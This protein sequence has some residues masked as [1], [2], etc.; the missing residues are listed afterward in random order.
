[1][2]SR[3]ILAA[4]TLGKEE[5]SEKD[6]KLLRELSHNVAEL[7]KGDRGAGWLR[8]EEKRLEVE[9]EDREREPEEEFWKWVE[10]PG[11]REAICRGYRTHEEKLALMRKAMFGKIDERIRTRKRPPVPGEAPR[12]TPGQAV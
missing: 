4:G 9:L 1:V 3:L 10:K 11:V 6:W 5:G 7:R 12:E 8:I 2:I